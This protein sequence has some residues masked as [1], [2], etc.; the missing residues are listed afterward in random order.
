MR[1]SYRFDPPPNFPKPPKA[2]ATKFVVLAGLVV[3]YVGGYWAVSRWPA[4][5][6]PPQ[7]V[8]IPVDVVK[9]R[10]RV[11]APPPLRPAMTVP[12]TVV[13]AP[14]RLVIRGRR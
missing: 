6:L 1:P 2:R 8:M 7:I 12:E 5:K 13:I 3:V 11:P 4:R 14:P 9:W 10:Q